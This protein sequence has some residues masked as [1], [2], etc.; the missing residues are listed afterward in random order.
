MIVL[1]LLSARGE[2]D[3]ALGCLAMEGGL[4][5]APRRFAISG[6]MSEAIERRRA[7]RAETLREGADRRMPQLP[8]L[9]AP[10]SAARIAAPA[11]APALRP[12]HGSGLAEP[13]AD[14]IPRPPRGRPNLRLVHSR[15]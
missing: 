12:V 7:E 2:T 10:A 11:T 3:L 9:A 4:G 1:P 8:P 14:F 13:P 6:L 15:D 5:R